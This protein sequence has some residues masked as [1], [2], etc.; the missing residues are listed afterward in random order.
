M[1][2]VVFDTSIYIPYLRGEAYNGLVERAVQSGRACQSAIVL[3]ELYAG[4]RSRRDK[5][6][7]D[8]VR[9]RYRAL[10]RLVTPDDD[11]WACAGQGIA[12]YRRLY[13]DNEARQHINDVLILLSSARVDAEVVTE[14]ARSFIRW[15]RLLRPVRPSLRVRAVERRAHLG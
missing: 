6:D 7:L 11:D 9:Q 4:T 5:T 1:S 15:A 8:I 13:G 3:C 2:L 12:R 14:D 10:N